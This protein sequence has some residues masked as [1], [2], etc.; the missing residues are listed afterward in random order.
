MKNKWIILFF[1]ILSVSILWIFGPDA[2]ENTADGHLSF[3]G[4]NT[5]VPAPSSLAPSEKPL[6]NYFKVE[7]HES[8]FDLIMHVI[9]LDLSNPLLEIRPVSSHTTLFGYEYLSKINEKWDARVSING[10]FSHTDGLL[11]GMYAI[12]NELYVPATGMYPVLFKEN[13]KVFIKDAS[14][15]VWIEGSV[16]LENFHFNKYPDREGLYVFTPAYGSQN[17]VRQPHLNIVVSGGEVR[18]SLISHDSCEIP[19]DGFL[20]SAIGE[21]YKKKLKDIE[22]GMNLKIVFET[23]SDSGKIAG[24]DWAYECGSWILKDGETVVPDFDTW[25]GTLNVRTPRTAVG[26]KDDGKMVFVVAD[27]RQK[28]LSDGLTGRELAERLQKMDVKDA[29]F[30]DGGA[31]S[32]LIID[33]EII[34]SPSAGRERML[35]SAFII[36]EKTQ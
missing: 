32:E 5:A 18:G 34:N 28:G 1:I 15:K 21:N 23:N 12:E 14:T 11:G 17:R 26:L 4:Q 6:Y 35:A 25:V 31:S 2:D 7:E 3:N 29:V 30:L 22:A 13:D 10:G 24:F 36:R 9:E 16:K 8:G 27:G 33:G 19:R 20:I